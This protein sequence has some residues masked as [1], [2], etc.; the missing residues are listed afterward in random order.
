MS[1]L[2]YSVLFDRKGN[3]GEQFP[4]FSPDFNQPAQAPS[5]MSEG[6]N[7]GGGA[8]VPFGYSAEQ[9][10]PVEESYSLDAGDLRTNLKTREDTTSQENLN[11]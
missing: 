3:M 6:D 11:L 9:S 8:A 4:S 2:L 5:F 1:V 10:I 7:L